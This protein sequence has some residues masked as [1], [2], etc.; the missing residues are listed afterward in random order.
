MSTGITTRKEEGKLRDWVADPGVHD[1]LTAAVGDVMDGDHFIA[2]ALVSFQDPKVKNCT[3]LSQF[4]ALHQ[5]AVLG[6]LPTLGQVVLIPYKN[7]IK[8]MPQW[9]GLKALMERHPSVLE[10]QAVIV[11]NGDSFAITNGDVQHSFD[12]FDE[13]RQIR[14]T[15]DI[16][17]G[18][19]KIVYADGRPPK[20]HFTPVAHI[21]KCRKCAQT[22][23]VWS[24]WPEQMILKTL[25]RDCYARR[26]VPMD[27]LVHSR[28]QKAFDLDDVNLGN[29]PAKVESKIEQ[30]AN[31][32]VEHP[33]I[34]DVEPEPPADDGINPFDE[35]CDLL[36]QCQ[37]TEEV[38]SLQAQYADL[39]STEAA[40]KALA[41]AE[42]K[43]ADIRPRGAN[44]NQKTLV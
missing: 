30:I 8:C 41:K 12:P 36:G 14:S 18:Y 37:T 28:L 7:E 40:E 1:Q 2:Q 35:F 39:F 25:Y 23:D 16:R 22:Q 11:A 42:M 19:C 10:V 29:S 17:G 31:Q 44:S 43:L 6:L 32:Q 3:P 33:Q 38:R 9:Q 24:K 13:T 5:L 26:A 15:A 21:D 20:Y 34:I 4:T 27:P